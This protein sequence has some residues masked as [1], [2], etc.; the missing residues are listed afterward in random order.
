MSLPQLAQLSGVS[1]ATLNHIENDVSD[2]RLSTVVAIAWT[3]DVN[4][5]QIFRVEKL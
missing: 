5:N 1:V 2:P 4:I 3:L